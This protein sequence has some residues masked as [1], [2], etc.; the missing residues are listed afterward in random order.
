MLRVLRNGT[1][2]GTIHAASRIK[3]HLVHMQVS[4]TDRQ[5]ALSSDW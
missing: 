5:F 4:D 1:D 3:C 2:Q